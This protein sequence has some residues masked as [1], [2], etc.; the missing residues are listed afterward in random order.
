MQKYSY[1]CFDTDTI[2]AS[3]KTS[4]SGESF[5]IGPVFLSVS[6]HDPSHMFRKPNYYWDFGDGIYINNTQLGELSHNFTQIKTCYVKVVIF[7][8]ANGKK[9]NGTASKEMKFSGM[10][11]C[12][13]TYM[14][15]I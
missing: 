10:N 5:Y 8:M 7:A 11:C 2:T 9:Y 12:Y 6:I 1:I 4:P 14:Y 13:L 3:I 15:C